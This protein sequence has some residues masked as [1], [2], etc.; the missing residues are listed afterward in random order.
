MMDV[1][2]EVAAKDFQYRMTIIDKA[3]DGIGHWHA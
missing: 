1:A 3:W 2:E